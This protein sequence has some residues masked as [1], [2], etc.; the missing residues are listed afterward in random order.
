MKKTPPNCKVHVKK[1]SKCG[2]VRDKGNEHKI[3]KKFV[4]SR[5]ETK[6]TG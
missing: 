5:S 6:G 4:N 1:V 2:W 3:H